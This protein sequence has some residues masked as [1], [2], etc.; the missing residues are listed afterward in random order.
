[1]GISKTNSKL[2]NN[3]L[4]N[5]S[6]VGDDVLADEI[7]LRNIS[8]K[9][10]LRLFRDVSKSV[11]AY[12]AFLNKHKIDPD[13][14]KNIS[15]FSKLP[16][17][18]KKNYIEKY[19]FAQRCWNGRLD[20]MHII[21]TS[22]GTTGAAHFWPRNLQNEIEGAYIHDL[23]FSEVLKIDKKTTL[24]INGFPMGNWIAGTFTSACVSLVAW[25]GFPLTLMSPGYDLPSVIHTL[26][27]MH[28][29]FEQIVICGHTPFLK[30]VVENIPKKVTGKSKII[31][32]GTGQAI[33]EKWREY[34]SSKL[35][36]TKKHLSIVNLYGSADAALMGF[37]TEQSIYL[38]RMLF[39]KPELNKNIF[40][41]ERIPSIYNYD[42]RFTYFDTEVK[43][44]CITKNLGCPLIRYN[45][46]D[47]GGVIRSSEI[48]KLVSKNN[49]PLKLP[50]VYL[51]G[52]DKFMI[53]IYGANVYSE[54]VQLALSHMSL[55]PLLTGRYVMEMGYTNK[56]NPEMVCKIELN[57]NIIPSADMI[58]L[59][60]QI[61]TQEVRKVNSEY[62]YVFEKF[63]N[64]VRPRIKLYKH[65][66]PKYFPKGKIRKSA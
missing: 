63:G 1:M 24:I 40:K 16:T 52:R 17:T 60:Q 7:K 2:L 42:S 41:S 57:F 46:Q 4:N 35:G 44:L 21:S 6:Q 45:I 14:I 31:L 28:K 23:I 34:V 5:K 59:I 32:L 20:G 18:T 50:F 10:A 29:H 11:P 36:Q 25:K 53:K 33:T 61:F 8:E 66:H 47:E 64:K 37:E 55:A 43:E 13:L 38:R 22:S 30:E 39:N 62:N 56:Q 19:S 26:E 65:G 15:D 51:Y 58:L 12:K 48:A 9:K 49:Q 27:S 54:H 3:W